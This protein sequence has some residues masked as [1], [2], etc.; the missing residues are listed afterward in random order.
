M[1]VANARDEGTAVRRRMPV[2]QIPG[3]VRK[4][5]ALSKFLRRAADAGFESKGPLQ[6]CTQAVS[7]RETLRSRLARHYHAL[8]TRSWEQKAPTF[9][10]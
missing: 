5:T 2:A 6:L 9:C 7:S 8:E 3:V 10:C 1:A 4:P